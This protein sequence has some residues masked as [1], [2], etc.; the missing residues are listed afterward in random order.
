MHVCVYIYIYIYIYIEREITHISCTHI[1]LFPR[2]QSRVW[3]NLKLV[4]GPFKCV[5][6]VV[7]Y[8]FVRNRDPGILS[9]KMAGFRNKIA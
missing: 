1:L 8:V 4:G 6:Y 9:T 5:N 7:E 2:Q 3:R